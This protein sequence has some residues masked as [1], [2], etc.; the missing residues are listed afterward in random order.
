MR[1]LF[2]VIAHQKTQYLAT[3]EEMQ[4][5]DAFNEKI[6]AAGQRILAIGIADPTTAIVFDNR[7]GA[8][9]VSEGPFA[10][11]DEF[12]AGIWII[13]AASEQVAHQLAHEASISCNRRIEVRAILG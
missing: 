7:N 5:I 12:V 6:E 11:A 4:A 3:N 9:L 8:R 10:D 1:F 13:E 2:S